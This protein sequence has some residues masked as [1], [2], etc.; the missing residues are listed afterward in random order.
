MIRL[1]AALLAATLLLA[2]PAQ[3]QSEEAAQAARVEAFAKLPYWPGYWVSEQYANTTIG[4]T[5]PPRPAG[6]PPLQ[7][8]NGFNA[9]WNDEG[10]ARQAQ[11]A[12]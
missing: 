2:V 8:L 12:R 10:R 6:S 5:A 11:A 1:A 4:G 9:P 3:A 7:R